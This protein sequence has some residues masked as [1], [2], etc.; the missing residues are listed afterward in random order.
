MTYDP[1]LIPIDK[2]D[3]SNRLRHINED[4]AQ[5]IAESIK[6]FQR[7]RAPI[8]VREVKDGYA[9]IAGGHRLR[10]AQI[11]GWTEI[12]AYVLKLTPDEARLAEIDENLVR[13]ELNPFD[14]AVFLAERKAL[15]ERLHPETAAGVAGGKARQGSATDTM[16][17]AKDTAERVGLTDRTIQ[18][19]VR[20][21]TMLTDNVKAM[22]GTSDRC[23]TQAELEALSKVPADLQY[24][25]LTEVM[26][27]MPVAAARNKVEGRKT[28]AP[29]DSQKQLNALLNAWRKAGATAR[30]SFL[31]FIQDDKQEAA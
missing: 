1:R 15:Y 26:H 28:D 7:L 20:I 3:I 29:N 27:G 24:A 11:L 14:R 5:F 2:I 8:E 12:P 10:A 6:E 31:E 17:F 18:R 4:Q 16:S 13:H 25:V 22:L 30:K 21:A 19:S 23:W 9:L